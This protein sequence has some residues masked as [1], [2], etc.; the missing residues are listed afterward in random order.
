MWQWLWGNSPKERN[1]TLDQEGT[2][3]FAIVGMQSYRA[4]PVSPSAA[5]QGWMSEAGRYS[6]IGNLMPVSEAY[7]LRSGQGTQMN[8]PPIGPVDDST[9]RAH[10]LQAALAASLM[11]Q[12]NAPRGG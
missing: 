10:A 2:W 1:A 11:G 3:P 7:V 5:P 8:L 4:Q 9:M 12:Q 6:Q